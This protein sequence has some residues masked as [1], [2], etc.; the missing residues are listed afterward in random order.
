MVARA[1]A[2][3]AE[4][5]APERWRQAEAA[6]RLAHQ[7]LQDRDYQGALSAAN[8]AAESARLALETI[9]PA[10]Q[11]ARSDAALGLAEV[12]A[13][14]DRAATERAGAVKAG[15]ARRTLEPLDAR[16]HDAE[17][18]M[19]AISQQ[20]EAGDYAMVADRVAALRTEV[21]PL[22]DLYRAARPPQDTKRPRARTR[23]RSAPRR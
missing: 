2:A 19:T 14:L 9:G 3:G 23:G 15:M 1:K 13:T 17:L 10:K 4:A 16:V 12:K 18:G 6:N 20:V 21:A 8:D 5:Y 11:K 7:R 22:P